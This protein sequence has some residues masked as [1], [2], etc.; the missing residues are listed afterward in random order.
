MALKTNSFQ[1]EKK[2]VFY[3]EL[4]DY[5]SPK[6][7]SSTRQ[8]AL[9]NLIYLDKNDENYLPFLVNGLTHFKWQFVKFSKDN[10]RKLLK[11]KNHQVYFEK[12]S[13]TISLN[14]KT[15]LDKLLKE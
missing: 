8:N 15:Q 9:T 10:I 13:A 4:L 2:V 6:F 1:Q 5:A 7:E 3:Q 14:E 11:N 12:L